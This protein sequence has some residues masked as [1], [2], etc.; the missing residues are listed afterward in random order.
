VFVVL[1]L[2]FVSVAGWAQVFPPPASLPEGLIP[3][4]GTFTPAGMPFPS[5]DRQPI[6]FPPGFDPSG[7]SFPQAFPGIP[8][9]VSSAAENGDPDAQYALGR[10]FFDGIE[11]PRDFTKAAHWLRLC[12]GRVIADAVMIMGGLPNDPR[13]V[14]EITLAAYH[15][16]LRAQFALGT[17][18]FTG[19]AKGQDMMQAAAIFMH[20][21][22]HRY[23]PSMVRKN[24]PDYSLST[25]PALKYTAET[26][27]ARAWYALGNRTYFGD[28]VEVDHKDAAQWYLR[29]AVRNAAWYRRLNSTRYDQT[30]WEELHQ[31]AEGG[32]I[33]AQYQLGT[34]F[35]LGREIPKDFSQAAYWLRRA[36][37]EM[38]YTGIPM[39]QDRFGGVNIPAWSDPRAS[40]PS[41]PVP[42]PMERVTFAADPAIAMEEPPAF[43]PPMVPGFGWGEPVTPAVTAPALPPQGIRELRRLA[44][45]GNV[46]AQLDLAS[47][48]YSGNGVTPNYAEAARFYRMAADSGDPRAQYA[49]EALKFRHDDPQSVLTAAQNGD[50]D[51]Q[52]RVGSWYQY[53]HGNPV[54]LYQADV[55]YKRAAERGNPHAQ[56]ALGIL[57]HHWKNPAQS[58]FWLRKSAQQ[59]NF[60]AQFAVASLLAS[61]RHSAVD[62]NEAVKWFEMVAEKGS[63]VAKGILAVMFAVGDGVPAD[64]VRAHGWYAIALRPEVFDPQLD[65]ALM[66]EPTLH[67]LTA[68]DQIF[69]WLT[70]LLRF[71]G[72]AMAPWQQLQ[73]MVGSRMSQAQ[74]AAAEILAQELAVK[75]KSPAIKSPA[76]ARGKKK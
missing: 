38:G 2:V 59:G 65:Y 45:T 63:L 18:Y 43:L 76:K 23:N 68:D 27:D 40:E 28:G 75:L 5:S 24:L 52:F 71:H 21:A 7:S 47:R 61:T 26:G 64:P 1:L 62:L 41:G 69:A 35:F 12:A 31:A 54:D 3:L 4:V 19:T 58:M 51:A 42:P 15:G 39:F 50:A 74:L 13:D 22:D 73:I 37:M 32:D 57:H 72:P 33:D 46:S 34:R 67:G 53:G 11:V 25:I 29:V 60:L 70:H 14:Q 9:D 48:Y 49:L 30:R 55:W 66:Q 17:M 10:R 16:D 56:F 36:G 20:V 44:E 6:P 8:G